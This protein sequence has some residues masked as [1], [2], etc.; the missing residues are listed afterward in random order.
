MLDAPMEGHQSA[1]LFGWNVTQEIHNVVGRMCSLDDFCLRG[2]EETDMAEGD[3][4][5]DENT[6]SLSSRP[7]CYIFYE[8]AIFCHYNQITTLKGDQTGRLGLDL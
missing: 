7:T 2:T 8:F 4:S 5:D 3:G 6:S 1:G